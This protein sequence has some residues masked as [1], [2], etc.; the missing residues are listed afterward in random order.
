MRL[1]EV[2]E[3]VVGEVPLAVGV[4]VEDG[5]R[6]VREGRHHTAFHVTEILNETFE[7]FRF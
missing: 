2:E 5:D 3:V 6:A 1:A 7:K 4:P